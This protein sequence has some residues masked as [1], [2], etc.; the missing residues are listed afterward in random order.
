MSCS[1]TPAPCATW[2]SRRRSARWA[3]SAGCAKERPETV[4][5]FLG[6]MAQARGAEL[7]DADL[8]HRRSRRRHAEISRRGRLR[9]QRSVSAKR[10]LA[11][12]T[13]RA[14]RSSTS[15]EEDRLAGDDPRTRAAAAAGH[16][17]RL[18]HAG[19]QHALH[20]L[21]R[22]ANARR[23]ARP[24]DRGDRRGSSRTGRARREGSHASRAD[25]ESLRTPRVPEGRRARVPFVQLLEAVH[26]VEGLERIRFTS[27]HPIGFRDDLV[28]ALRDLPKLCEHVHLPMQSGS[29]RILKAMHRTY[30]AEKY[31][32]LVEQI[33]AAR[34]DIA[35][36]TDVI[37]GFPGET[38]E[39]YRAD[40]RPGRASS[41]STMPSSS[42]TRRAAT[43]RR[44]KW[45]GS[46]TKKVKEARNQDLLHGGGCSARS[47]GE[48]IVGRTVRSPLR[49]AE[50]DQRRTPD[51]ANAHEQDRGLRGERDRYRTAARST[52]DDTRPASVCPG[53]RFRARALVNQPSLDGFSRAVSLS[54]DLSSSLCIA[55]GLVTGATLVAAQP[56][57]A[58]SAGAQSFLPQFPALH[59]SPAYSS[60]RSI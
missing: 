39:D 27:P 21:H 16:R 59:A 60:S 52:G 37:V 34:P 33:R 10:D 7:L 49:R 26:E 8:P 6:C 19:L 54:D 22:A 56:A 20:L 32:R 13:T 18:H 43:R 25:R 31:L 35:L 9:G 15:T 48:R 46:S 44:R 38:D 4:F 11:G 23:G 17:L 28:A 2:R 14:S 58:F 51:W 3:C 55:A 47:A 36:T 42:V 29:D 45:T 30:T 12:W 1:S 53:Q 50:Q 5:G 41:S 57:R 24:A 40:T